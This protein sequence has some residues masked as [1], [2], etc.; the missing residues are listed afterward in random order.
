MRVLYIGNFQPPHSTEN[1]IRI[2]LEANGVD[3]VQAQE[4]L[5]DWSNTGVRNCN[6]VLWTHSHHFTAPENYTKIRRFEAAQRKAKRPMI[7]YHL[8]RWMGLGREVQLTYDPYFEQSL[9]CTA[10]GGHDEA[11]AEF[12]INHLWFPPAV[13]HVDAER[14]VQPKRALARKTVGF[15]GS[16]HGYHVEWAWREKLV[17]WLRRTYQSRLA[18]YPLY[19]RSLRGKDLNVLYAS[20]P[21]IVGD[22]CLAPTRTGEPITRY[23]SDRIPETIGRGGFLLHPYVEGIDEHFMPGE[24][25]ITYEPYDVDGLADLIAEWNDQPTEREHIAKAG[26]E[27]V[28]D[29]HTYKHRMERLLTLVRGGAADWS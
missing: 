2:A 4:N 8:D 7:G 17:L 11:W 20:V 28:L 14:I 9:L 10:D 22:S 3:V 29:H 16:W 26:R 13:S 12:G 25:F 15:C 5:F 27:H 19:G 21:V 24:H 1:E 18:L 23:W 6:F